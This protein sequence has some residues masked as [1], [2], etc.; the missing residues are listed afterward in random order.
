MGMSK[1]ELLKMH[2]LCGPYLKCEP[3]MPIQIG[4]E[5]VITK[6]TV[7]AHIEDSLSMKEHRKI[8]D[9]KWGYIYIHDVSNLTIGYLSVMIRRS[10][11][12][13]CTATLTRHLTW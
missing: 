6:P 13:P 12:S 8:Q 1:I 4:K 5:V 7:L 9:D 11:F 2:H 3:L 10:T